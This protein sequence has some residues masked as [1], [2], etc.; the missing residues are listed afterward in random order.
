MIAFHLQ[1]DSGVRPALSRKFSRAFNWTNGFMIIPFF[2]PCRVD[3]AIAGLEEA[4]NRV[5]K[6]LRLIQ[7]FLTPPE[8]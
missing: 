5:G 4:K 3:S 8:F 2:L 6:V 7:I 1:R